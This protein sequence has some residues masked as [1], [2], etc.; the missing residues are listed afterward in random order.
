MAPANNDNGQGCCHSRIF[1][2]VVMF[3]LLLFHAWDIENM[4]SHGSWENS[5]YVDYI[6]NLVVLCANKN[7]IPVLQVHEVNLGMAQKPA[8]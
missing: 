7:I 5:S 2:F 8:A 1:Q 6:S 3:C 4:N